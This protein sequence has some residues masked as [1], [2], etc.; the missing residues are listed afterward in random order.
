MKTIIATICAVLILN[1]AGCSDPPLI[2]VGKE[3]LITV[4]AT[5]GF[6]AMVDDGHYDGFDLRLNNKM[7]EKD[8]DLLL[9]MLAEQEKG[10]R[11]ERM[12]TIS[13]NNEYPIKG[14]EVIIAMADNHLRPATMGECLA[15]GTEIAKTKSGLIDRQNFSIACLG[16]AIRDGDTTR[17]LVLNGGKGNL[18]LNVHKDNE[19]MSAF[20]WNRYDYLFSLRTDT[21][22]L[23]WSRETKFL[24]IRN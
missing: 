12:V 16:A 9:D 23:G 11:D 19:T 10:V 8:G 5:N 3:S 22:E 18:M 13:F 14:R 17:F 15:Y 7:F 4:D 20:I 21:G 6:K 2:K 24:A 1:L